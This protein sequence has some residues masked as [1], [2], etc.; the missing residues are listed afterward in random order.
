MMVAVIPMSN[1]Q[2][3]YQQFRSFPYYKV[4]WWDEVSLCWRPVQKAH[5]SIVAATAAF[6]P[7]MRCRIMEIREDGRSP[8]PA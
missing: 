4:Q 3:A 2:Y 5:P 8:L 1:K 6:L 7:D